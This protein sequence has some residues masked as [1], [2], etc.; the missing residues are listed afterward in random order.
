MLEGSQMEARA[1]SHDFSH[2]SDIPD[3][4]LQGTASSAYGVTTAEPEPELVQEDALSEA[5]KAI[6]GRLA[7]LGVPN[8]WGF[9]RISAQP[10]NEYACRQSMQPVLTACTCLFLG[11]PLAVSS[12]SK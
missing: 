9:A 2:S 8:K 1:R 5:K 12:S 6:Q 10:P 3:M 4:P 7:N 11:V